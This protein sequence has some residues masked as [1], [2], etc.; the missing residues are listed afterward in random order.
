MIA[1][2]A[3][4]TNTVCAVAIYI[5][6]I[7]HMLWLVMIVS[8]YITITISTFFNSLSFKFK[9]LFFFCIL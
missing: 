5:Y 7:A 3:N 4:T 2:L 6:E 1:S 9:N 8:M